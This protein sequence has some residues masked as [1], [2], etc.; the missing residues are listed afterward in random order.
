MPPNQN[1]RRLILQQINRAPLREKDEK[2]AGSA[3][4]RRGQFPAMKIDRPK[5]VRWCSA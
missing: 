2:D 4:R 3:G 5:P 1:H